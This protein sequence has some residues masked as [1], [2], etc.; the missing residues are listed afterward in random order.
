[1]VDKIHEEVPEM[2]TVNESGSKGSAADLGQAIVSLRQ[3]SLGNILVGAEGRTLYLLT[4]DR[5]ANSTCYGDCAKYWPPMTTSG[6]PLGNDGIDATKLGVSARTDGT[7]M[8]TFNG[9]PLYYFIQDS[10]AGDVAGQG[11][12]N[13]WY[14]LDANGDA[15]TS[16]VA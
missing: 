5:D 1:L 13:V 2:N 9:H 4:S 7:T 6:M 10:N 12:N 14:A 15:I 3:T 11:S 16:Q 8:V